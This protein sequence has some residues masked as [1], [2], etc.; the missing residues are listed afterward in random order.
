MQENPELTT[1]EIAAQLQKPVKT[2]NALAN[3]RKKGLNFEKA[4]EKATGTSKIPALPYRIAPIPGKGLGLVATRKIC[5]GE[6]V[7]EEKPVLTAPGGLIGMRK[8]QAQFDALEASVQDEIMAL[9]DRNAS[10]G[11]GK[12]LLGVFGTNA[13]PQGVGSPDAAMCLVISRANHSCIS[14][15]YHGWVDGRERLYADVDIDCGGEICTNYTQWHNPTAHRQRELE[16]KF[17]FLCDCPACTEEETMRKKHDAIRVKIGE[18]DE[19]IPELYA[20]P[21][22]AVALVEQ[23]LELY[24][25]LG[26]PT[27]YAAEVRHCFDAYQL[28]LS[29]RNLTSAK[30]WIGRAYAAMV[31]TDGPNAPQTLRFKRFMQNPMSDCK[32]HVYSFLLCVSKSN[33]YGELC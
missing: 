13:L 31:V 30:R 20:M 10:D 4:S 2:V 23:V 5:R 11:H 29:N 6:L 14:N 32:G 8:L 7:V 25:K 22:Q 17:G 9:H 33:A 12:T 26:R 18:L 16:T 28:S 24:E 21:N 3:A 19:A 15:C 27:P 1:S